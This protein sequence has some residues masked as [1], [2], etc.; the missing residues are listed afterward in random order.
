MI[1]VP[2]HPYAA[3]DGAVREACGWHDPE[4]ATAEENAILVRLVALDLN[5][6]RASK[7]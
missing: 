1:E 5:L 7:P 4:P 2:Q 6:G 3:V